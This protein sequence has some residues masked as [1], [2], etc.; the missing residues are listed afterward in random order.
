MKLSIIIPAYN[1]E[2]TI[3][4]LI[5]KVKSVDLGKI[6]KE[7]IV[8]NDGSQDGT[9]EVLKKIPGIMHIS[10]A[11]NSGKGAAVTTGF[12]TA[13]GDILLIQDADLE[14]DPRDYMTVIRPIL[15]KQSEV[16]LG[17]RFI[18]YRPKF[19][20]RRRSPYLSHYIG[21][22]L[23]TSVTNL[24]YGRRFSDYEGCY[25]AFARNVIASTPI[26]AKGFEFDNELVC[27]LMRKGVRMSEVAIQY[28]PRSYENG[29]K[30][31][32]RHGVLMLWTI[33]KW[34]FLPI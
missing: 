1:E 14:Y 4:T 18:L 12:K 31:N 20:G 3:P 2:R 5:E 17:S 11:C 34:R 22:M 19:F 7:S 13:T 32:W 9:Q 25:K 6:E 24:L 8:V 28:T 29:K 33:L 16:V 30:I 15:D 27:K 10:H 26:T 23:I 21:N